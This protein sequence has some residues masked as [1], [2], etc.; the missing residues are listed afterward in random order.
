MYGE[1][2]IRRY[3]AQKFDKA[4]YEI[5]FAKNRYGKPYLQGFQKNFHF[6]ISHAGN[7]I[8]CAYDNKQVGIDI[9]KVRNLDIAR[10]FFSRNECEQLYN[11]VE[12]ERIDYFFNLWTL[13]ESYVKAVGKGLSIELDSFSVL[14]RDGLFSVVIDDIIQPWHLKQYFL[15]EN[16]K[17]AICAR[18]NKFPQTLITI[19]L[20]QLFDFFL[21]KNNIQS[22]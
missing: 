8:A 2:L 3:V 15:D 7:Y 19:S 4:N 10:N 18:Q 22:V 17:L 6:N 14:F 9:E 13:K 20:N 12:H 5:Q 1:L 11:I 21:N 16:H